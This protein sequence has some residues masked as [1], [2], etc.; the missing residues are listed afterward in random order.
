M[1]MATTLV[2]VFDDYSDA[3]R[4]CDRLEKEGIDRSMMKL[5]GG[6]TTLTETSTTHEDHRGFFARLF[7][8]DEP[9][10]DSATYAEAVRRGSNVVTVTLADEGRLDDIR[11]TM[12]DCGAIDISRRVEQWKASGYTGYDP[13]APRYSAADIAKERETFKVMQEDLKIGKREVQ[14][15]GVRVVQRVSEEPVSEQVTLREEKAVVERRPVDREASSAEMQAFGAQ[16]KDIEIRETREEPVVSKTARVIEEVDVGKKATERTETVRETVRRTDV[17]VENLSDVPERNRPMGTTGTT[18]P[19]TGTAAGMAGTSAAYPAG[20]ATNPARSAGTAG[21]GGMAA[22]DSAGPA[23]MPGEGASIGTSSRGFTTGSGG[24]RRYS[25]P[26]R[27]LGS[28]TP[29]TGVERRI[30]PF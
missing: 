17:D 20:T 5:T 10:E 14:S 13:T 24:E 12:E 29:Y 16:D 6:D 25:G 23:A 21:I 15:G 30:N 28:S 9:D 1:A 22:S 2:G 19:T 26:E 11:R 4:A 3:Q 27:R 7:G 8:L 18:D